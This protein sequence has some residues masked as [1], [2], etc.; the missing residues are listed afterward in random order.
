MWWTWPTDFITLTQKLMALPEQRQQMHTET[1]S[2]GLW[3]QVKPGV[4]HGPL[5]SAISYRDKLVIYPLWVLTPDLCRKWSVSLKSKQRQGGRGWRS[6]RENILFFKCSAAITILKYKNNFIAAISDW[7]SC[8]RA[9]EGKSVTVNQKE[10]G[11]LSDGHRRRK[12]CITATLK[13]DYH[14][15]RRY[16]IARNIIKAEHK[17]ALVTD[18]I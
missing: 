7:L 16:I 4:G 8:R 18:T 14:Q 2:C 1:Q 9:A 10:R 5:T 17:H 6:V 13:S 11:I 15:R 3:Y 12:T